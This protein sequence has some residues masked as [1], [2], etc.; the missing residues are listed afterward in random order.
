M[1]SFNVRRDDRTIRLQQRAEFLEQR[2]K[3]AEGVAGVRG[4]RFDK[5]ERSALLW[6]LEELERLD[7]IEEAVSTNELSEGDQLRLIEAIVEQRHQPSED[8]LARTGGL[9]RRAED[10]RSVERAISTTRSVEKGDLGG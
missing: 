9:R 7:R 5:A 6:A 4:L 1:R 2:I 10:D 3:N 8:D